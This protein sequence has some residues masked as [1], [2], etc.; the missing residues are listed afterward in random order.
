MSKKKE[1]KISASIWTI[2][3]ILL[4]CCNIF[5]LT[6][7]ITKHHSG[8]YIKDIIYLLI[9]MLLVFIFYHETKKTGTI[10][11]DDER[12]N[13]IQMKAESQAFNIIEWILPLSA[14][15]LMIWA[16]LV[17]NNE[18][19]VSVLGGIAIVL[20]LLWFVLII[21]ELILLAVNYHKN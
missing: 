10:N 15:A 12:D 21:L 20:N 4:M 11:N 14:I 7:D 6:I 1:A 5:F 16:S 8:N 3:M 18:I 13:F 2:L 9:S 19:A 17:K